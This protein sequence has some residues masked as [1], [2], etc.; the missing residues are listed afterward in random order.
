MNTIAN[1]TGPQGPTGSTG[2]VNLDLERLTAGLLGKLFGVGSS[3]ASNIAG[4]VALIALLGGIVI[5]LLLLNA[6][7]EAPY[8]VWKYLAPIIT[9]ALGFIFGKK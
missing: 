1:P 6:G 7:K 8:E 3:A 5:N 9:G 2:S 4:L